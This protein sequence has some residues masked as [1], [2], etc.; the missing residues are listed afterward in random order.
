MT[1][2][3]ERDAWRYLGD[4]AEKRP[5]PTTRRFPR[6]SREAFGH[7]GHAITGYRKPLWIAMMQWTTRIAIACTIIALL[8]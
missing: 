5:F 2:P 1:R 3:S 8:T 6:S 7:E 4:R